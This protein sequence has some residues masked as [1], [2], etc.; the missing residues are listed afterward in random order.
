MSLNYRDNIDIQPIFALPYS[1]HLYSSIKIGEFGLLT[2]LVS[3]L[4][5]PIFHFLFS[6]I[7]PFLT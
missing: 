6:L 4:V 2:I 1:S 5:V 3:F 7:D